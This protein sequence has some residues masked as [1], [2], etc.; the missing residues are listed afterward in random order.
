MSS[1]NDLPVAISL[2]DPA[3]IGP[4][5]S[6]K[7]VAALAKK[8][9]RRPVVMVGDAHV[10]E[11]AA[12]FLPGRFRAAAWRGTAEPG[13]VYLLETGAMR[14]RVPRGKDSAECGRASFSYFTRAWELLGEGTAACL[15]TAPISK[16]AW[17]MAGITFPGHTE[18]LKQFT[19][20]KV[21]ML[22][23]AGRLRVL[24]ATTHIPLR[25]LWTHLGTERLVEAS[26]A[27]AA[28]IARYYGSPVRL[29]FCGLN[30][31]A[32]ESGTM[33]SEE[34]DII[35]PAVRILA[36]RGVRAEGPFPADAIFHAAL[37][38]KRFSCIVALYHDQG[39]IPLKTF[40]SRSLVNI[41]TSLEWI[42]TS[43]GHG[44]AFDIAHTGAADP[45]SMIEAIRTASRFA[46]KWIS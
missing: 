16:A 1:R 24:L 20:E 25:D 43:P 14:G 15:V 7:A 37:A 2:G 11:T 31:H 23:A 32:G 35:R 42:R 45:S 19:G 27:A 26:L 28:F 10:L 5:V 22:M 13:G 6:V 29:G 21:E 30:P 9:F 18:A 8:K 40:F 33:G 41:S 38:E 12:A 3:G 46:S 44:T 4:E 17:H 39:M 34:D 36:E